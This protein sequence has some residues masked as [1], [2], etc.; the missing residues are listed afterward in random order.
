NVN[1]TH[2]GRACLGEQGLD[3]TLAEHAVAIVHDVMAS[4]VWRRAHASPWRF[5]EIPFQ[6]LMPP[7]PGAIS[8]VPTILRGVIDLVFREADGWVV[9]DYKTDS[10]SEA[11]LPALVAHYR[12]QMKNCADFWQA[13]VGE[14]V[15]EQGLYFTHAKRYLR[16]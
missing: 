11:E 16:I 1:L 12:G 8:A 6:T 5:S 15:V 3:A 14:P 7:D 2:L 4:D 10:R 13:T 9:L